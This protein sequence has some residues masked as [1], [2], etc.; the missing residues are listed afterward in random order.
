VRNKR[1]SIEIIYQLIKAVAF[2]RKDAPAT[3]GGVA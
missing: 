2:V 3:G 1:S